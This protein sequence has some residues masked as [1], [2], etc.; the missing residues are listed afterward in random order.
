MHTLLILLIHAEG[1][2]N[3]LYV[4]ST[5]LIFGGLIFVYL[6]PAKQ[7]KKSECQME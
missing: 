3:I 4:K 5:D 1:K 6:D 2:N 7:C